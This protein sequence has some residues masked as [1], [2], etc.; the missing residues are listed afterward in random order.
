MVWR[1]EG[2]FD[3]C[4]TVLTVFQQYVR[5]DD[6]SKHISLEVFLALLTY[7]L[8]NTGEKGFS[9]LA[10]GLLYVVQFKKVIFLLRQSQM[11]FL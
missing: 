4:F 11:N 6:Y 3:C 5:D 2:M 1:M 7:F 8:L 10:K 9:F